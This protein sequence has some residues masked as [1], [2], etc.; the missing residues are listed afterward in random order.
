MAASLSTIAA[1][2]GAAATIT[3]GLQALDNSGGGTGPFTLGQVLIAPTGALAAYGSGV[4]GATVL[5]VALATDSAGAGVAEASTTSGQTGSLVMGAGLAAEKAAVTNGQ[6]G[7]FAM[8][9]TGKQVGL[10]YANPENTLNGTTAA[11]TGTS[12]TQVIAA[13]TGS[14]RVYATDVLVTNSHASVGTFVN[15]LDGNGGSVLWSGYAAPA[16]GGYAKSFLVPLRGT[17]ATRLDAVCITT[18]ANVVVSVSGYK[19]I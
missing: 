18:G 3:G 6:T 11:M 9:L 2:D 1:K 13:Q 17:A 10:P 7:S 15:I 14:N 16:G 19:G 8:T 12:S 5:R 4:N